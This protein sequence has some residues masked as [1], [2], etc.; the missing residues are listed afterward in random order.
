MKQR[1]TAKG[2]LAQTGGVALIAVGFG[3]FLLGILTDIQING[4]TPVALMLAGGQ[5]MIMGTIL[6]CY[7]QLLIRSARNEDALQY[8][9]DMGYETGWRERGQQGRPVVVDFK[10]RTAA[11]KVIERV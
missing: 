1:I 8:Q 6:Y 10:A 7:Q 2:W 3:A 5:S 4:G 9:Y 11:E